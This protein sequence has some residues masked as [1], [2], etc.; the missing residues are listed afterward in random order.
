MPCAGSWRRWSHTLVNCYHRQYR[1]SACGL[2]RITLDS[3]LDFLR[4][5]PLGCSLAGRRSLEGS[6]VMELKYDGTIA[7]LDRSLLNYFPFRVTRMSKY[8]TGIE[9]THL[10]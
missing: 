2:Y 3:R 6:M 5:D 10:W 1:I 4:F 8:V 7:D 9:L